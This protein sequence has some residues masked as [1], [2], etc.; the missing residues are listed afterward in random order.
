MALKT[1][2]PALIFTLKRTCRYINRWKIQLQ[3]HVPPA[4]VPL[5]DGVLEACEALLAELPE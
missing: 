4:A 1:W 3:A 5:L 2:I